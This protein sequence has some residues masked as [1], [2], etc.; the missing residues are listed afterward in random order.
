MNAIAFEQNIKQTPHLFEIEK[1]QRHFTKKVLNYILLS[2]K[3]VIN[4][5]SKIPLIFSHIRGHCTIKTKFQN[6]KL[7]FSL[8]N[9]YIEGSRQLL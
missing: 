1:A 7:S 8:K 5:E 4:R 6:S 2:I 3:G 9:A